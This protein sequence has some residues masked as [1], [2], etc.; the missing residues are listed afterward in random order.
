MN[1]QEVVKM[2][3]EILEVLYHI[4]GIDQEVSYSSL[5][6]V[7]KLHSSPDGNPF[8]EDLQELIDQQDEHGD[9]FIGKLFR[10]IFGDKETRQARKAARQ[11]KRAARREKRAQKKADKRAYNLAMADAN[12]SNGVHESD[13][14]SKIQKGTSVVSDIL[15]SISGLLNGGGMEEDIP[16]YGGGGYDIPQEENKM[17]KYLPFIIGGIAIIGIV[18]VAILTGKKK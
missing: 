14:L 9:E 11:E 3:P 7:I 2:Y 1:I 12:A 4:Y 6:A 10:A 16:V 8:L 13:T 15:G 18:V 5:K 17:K